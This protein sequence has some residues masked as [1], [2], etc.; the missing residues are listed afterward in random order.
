[1]EL[2]VPADDDEVR[3]LGLLSGDQIRPV[4]LISSLSSAAA[5]F[6]PDVG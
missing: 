4:S 1:M 5:A 6:F 3:F 2:G